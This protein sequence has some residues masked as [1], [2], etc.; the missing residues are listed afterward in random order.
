MGDFWRSFCKFMGF[1][2]SKT[3]QQML[4]APYAE[5]SDQRTAMLIQNAVAE[6]H[7]NRAW[8]WKLMEDWP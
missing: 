4:D 3:Y 1:V 6:R 8:V 2:E 5:T 7:A